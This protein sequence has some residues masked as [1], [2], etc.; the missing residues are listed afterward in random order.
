MLWSREAMRIFGETPPAP[1]GVPVAVWAA[2]G[3]RAVRS[4]GRTAGGV[5]KAA[6]RL[7]WRHRHGWRHVRDPVA[8]RHVVQRNAKID[9]FRRERA[10]QR[11][12]AARPLYEAI[13]AEREEA[14][15]DLVQAR[16]AAAELCAVCTVGGAGDY[17]MYLL[18]GAHPPLHDP[19]RDAW[20]KRI[21]RCRRWIL[22]QLPPDQAQ[23]L[24]RGRG[25]EPPPVPSLDWYA[26]RFRSR[27][28]T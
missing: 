22:P 16:E 9:A 15:A 17:R 19:T 7:V 5:V 4:S 13:L 6:R 27:E 3:G 11:R 2:A 24:A 1:P 18:T 21:Q 8:W 26:F 25:T 12:E 23:L 20:D 10:Q 14:R 28:H